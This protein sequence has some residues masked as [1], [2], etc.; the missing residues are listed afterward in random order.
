M[1][2]I[3]LSWECKLSVLRRAYFAVFYVEGRVVR[4]QCLTP[5]GRVS[6]IRAWQ[7]F[8]NRKSVSQNKMCK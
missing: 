6:I 3:Q 1:K 4:D 5:L 8:G 7:H 2:Y